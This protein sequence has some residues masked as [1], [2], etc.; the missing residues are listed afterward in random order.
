MKRSSALIPAPT[1]GI[2]TADMEGTVPALAAA[3][4]KICGVAVPYTVLA[5]QV[6]NSAKVTDHHAIV[7]PPRE[8]AGRMWRPCLPGNGKS[9]SGGP[10]ASVCHRLPLPL[11]GNGCHPGLRAGTSFL[12]KVRPSPIGW[13]AYQREKADPANESFLPDGLT[14]GMTLPITAVT[15]KEG[16]TT[17]P[18]HYTEDTLLSA[19]E[20]AGAKD[21][22][23]GCG[24]QGHRHTGDPRRYLRKAGIHRLCG[25]QETEKGHQPHSHADRRFPD[26]RPAGAASIATLDCGMGTPAQRGRARRSEAQR[27]HGRYLQYAPGPGGDLQGD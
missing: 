14:E 19:M 11:P 13:K 10:G 26:Y 21:M 2:L 15:I 5:A 4:A 16:K 20:M 3:A 27:V 6:C 7:P 17:A 1:A 9:A 24:A 22:A 25:A 23:G 12:P 18:K 8:L